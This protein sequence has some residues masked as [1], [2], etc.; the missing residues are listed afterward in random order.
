MTAFLAEHRDSLASL[1]QVTLVKTCG[2][3]G[4]VADHFGLHE[5][6]AVALHRVD[7]W[8]AELPQGLYA[9]STDGFLYARECVRAQIVR[10]FVVHYRQGRRD[11]ALRVIQ[12]CLAILNGVAQDILSR[13]LYATRAQAYR[14][15]AEIYRG[16]RN[17]ADARDC[18]CRALQL[19][20]ER[21]HHEISRDSV[22][23]SRIEEETALFQHRQALCFL[24]QARIDYLSGRGC[25]ADSAAAAEALLTR[26]DFDRPTTHLPPG[27]D[28]RV[29]LLAR[30]WADPLSAATARLVGGIVLR[31][32]LG[33]SLPHE[34]IAGAEALIRDAVGVFELMQHGPKLLWARY[35]LAI[36]LVISGNVDAADAMLDKVET[37][38]SA[39]IK[40]DDWRGLR[41]RRFTVLVNGRR[42]RI[43]RE[44]LVDA[45]KAL[46]HAECA[47]RQATNWSLPRQAID[48][49][50]ARA[51]S[52][53]MFDDPK[54]I[55]SAE[56]DLERARRLVAEV[57]P[58]DTHALAQIAA[59]RAECRVGLKDLPGAETALRHAETL[60]RSIDHT[61]IQL[62][63]RKVGAKVE[64]LRGSIVLRMEEIGTYRDAVSRLR[65]FVTY[66][67]E[68]RGMGPEE[69]ADHLE[70]GHSTYYKWRE[71]EEPRP[72]V[73][74]RR[75]RAR[76]KPRR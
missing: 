59:R 20:K 61:N 75:S 5:H 29:A 48:A 73:K 71:K 22:P 39:D 21:L 46:A 31:N 63:V 47:V 17:Y 65:R 53:L 14:Y 70:I 37:Q 28:A 25:P 9:E 26:P 41:A 50:I 34:R 30:R 10:A 4:E 8:F 7:A 64:L 51:S 58:S 40:H 60:A 1:S 16:S 74:R 35:E 57:A 6:A 24:A 76:R 19:F 66:A 55:E 42:S 56:A 27:T 69:A 12:D 2:M 45:D 43:A 67:L 13:Q 33:Q 32:S 15:L 68:Q 72:S 54:K 49:L 3:L 11:E 52:Q 18:V 62:L 23:Q 36:Q 44:L 38:A